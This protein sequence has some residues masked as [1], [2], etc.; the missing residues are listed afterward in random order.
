MILTFTC[1]FP[2]VSHRYHH[3]GG[4]RSGLMSRNES[5]HGLLPVSLVT[6]SRPRA[7]SCVSLLS[8]HPEYVKLC[9]QCCGPLGQG[10]TSEKYDRDSSDT[11]TESANH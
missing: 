7:P 3:S 11:F 4:E 8:P 9:P 6:P 2:T 5:P 1:S 10:H